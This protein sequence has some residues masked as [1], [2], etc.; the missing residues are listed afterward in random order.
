MKKILIIFLLFFTTAATSKTEQQ[1]VQNWPAAS[2]EQ[3]ERSQIMSQIAAIKEQFT[4]MGA[5]LSSP[6]LKSAIVQLLQQIGTPVSY[7][8]CQEMIASGEL[9]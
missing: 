1:K 9:R 4:S 8:I 2:A 6:A 7:T 5:T 3:K